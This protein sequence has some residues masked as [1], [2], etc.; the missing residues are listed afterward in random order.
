LTGV[1]GTLESISMFTPEW[2]IVYV[3]AA[4]TIISTLTLVAIY[5]QYRST[6]EAERAVLVPLW[7]NGV[8]QNPEKKEPS[9]CFQWN[10]TNWGKGPAFVYETSAE[11][12]LLESIDDLPKRPKYGGSAHFK[13]DPVPPQ[14][15]LECGLFAP[16]KDPRRYEV[17]Q[18]EY[19]TGGKLLYVYGFVRYQDMFGREHETRFGLRYR[20]DAEPNRSIDGFLVDGPKPYNKYT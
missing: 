12:I 17:I 6:Q 11:M 13:G 9:H 14:K 8:Q 2:V 19:R 4:Y 15:T 7:E 18:A 1:L 5:K 10:F 3:T 16:M 20:A